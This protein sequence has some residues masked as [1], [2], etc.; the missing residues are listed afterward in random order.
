MKY[1]KLLTSLNLI[2]EVPAAMAWTVL[3]LV[4]VAVVSWPVFSS[5]L[6]SA[7]EMVAG[8]AAQAVKALLAAL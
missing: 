5:V 8:W 7:T 3:A 1:L 6:S 2:L 4:A